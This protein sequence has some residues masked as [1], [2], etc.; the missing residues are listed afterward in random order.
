MLENYHLAEQMMH[1]PISDLQQSQVSQAGLSLSAFL[2]ILIAITFLAVIRAS[3]VLLCTNMADAI[4]AS[5]RVETGTSRAIK[6]GFSAAWGGKPGQQLGAITD[7]YPLQIGHR[8]G[9][10]TTGQGVTQTH[11]GDKLCL[12]CLQPKLATGRGRTGQAEDCSEGE[13]GV[14]NFLESEIRTWKLIWILLEKS[15]SQTCTSNRFFVFVSAGSRN[16]EESQGAFSQ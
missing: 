15:Q 13:K 3:F 16:G 5:T 10:V 11:H 6:A 12:K 1:T 8:C 7:Q 4:L 9:H 14:S 2:L